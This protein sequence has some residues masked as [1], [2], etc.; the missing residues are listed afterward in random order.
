[1]VGSM[2]ATRFKA[3]KDVSLRT[4]VIDELKEAIFSGRLR[5]GE[6]LPELKLAH[7]FQVSQATVR[8]ALNN[9]EVLGLIERVRNRRTNVTKFSP[10]EMT[11]R[12]HIR[13][14]LEGMALVEAA[15]KM[16]EAAYA[17][18]DKLLQAFKRA[19]RS[20]DV[21]ARIRADFE[22][23]RYLWKVSGNR[24]L[25]RMLEQLTSPLFAY[26]SI[27]RIQGYV[28]APV[29]T[30]P[31][32]ALVDAL[33]TGEPDRIREAIRSHIEPSVASFLQAS[34]L[35]NDDARKKV[36]QHGV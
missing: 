14:V 20:G 32:E 7:E 36:K 15:G 17:E 22:I 9:L 10:E 13:V 1:M 26:I 12:A 31:H 33:R 23:H 35:T 2:Q 6:P 25:Q 28:R 16:T 8:E 21:F 24:T 5:P 19:V 29:I 34:L 4:K 27:L 18:L 30:N 11:E 3:L